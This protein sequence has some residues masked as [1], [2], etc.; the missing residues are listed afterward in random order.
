MIR[1]IPTLSS[2][3]DALESAKVECKD[4]TPPAGSVATPASPLFKGYG[5]KRNMAEVEKK[6]TQ[7]AFREGLFVRALGRTCSSNP[8]PPNSDES[9][10]WEKG[11]R[12]VDENIPPTEAGRR[13]KLVPE[14]M[15]GVALTSSRQ[16][17]LKPKGIVI[18]R[19]RLADALRIAA[20]IAIIIVMLIALRW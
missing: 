20:G 15:P 19:V 7:D 5:S 4:T 3:G 11:W 17:P 6:Q 9:A 16:A 14:F 13:V 1:V 18:P 10:L 2:T 12:S 8:Y